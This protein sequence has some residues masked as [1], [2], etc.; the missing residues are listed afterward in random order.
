MSDAAPSDADRIA[1]TPIDRRRV[2]SG[3]GALGLST[4]ILPPTSAHASGLVGLNAVETQL[5]ANPDFTDGTQH[6][7]TDTSWDEIALPRAVI[8]DGLLTFTGYPITVSQSVAFDAQGITRVEARVLIRRQPFEEGQEYQLRLFGSGPDRDVDGLPEQTAFAVRTPTANRTTAPAEWTTVTVGI[9]AADY[10]HFALID[11]L[12]V[13]LNGY[14]TW[15]D[16][17]RPSGPV[18]DSLELFATQAS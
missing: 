3:A 18:V 2:L 8:A 14:D 4:L 13:S 12:F 9:D 10:E 5:L 15:G 16:D 1:R 11:E 7:R 17:D 6:W